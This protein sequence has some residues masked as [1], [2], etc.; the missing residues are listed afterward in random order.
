[1]KSFQKNKV[2]INLKY[3]G[4]RIFQFFMEKH[5]NEHIEYF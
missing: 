4:S 1:M 3:Y 2:F 5:N